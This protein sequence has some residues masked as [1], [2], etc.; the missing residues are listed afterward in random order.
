MTRWLRYAVALGVG[1]LGAALVF[2]TLHLWADHEALHA[3]IQ[4][5]AARQ[6]A[7][8]PSGQPTGR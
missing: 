2:V 6:R 3:L 8:L 5:E 4:I 7:T 1:A